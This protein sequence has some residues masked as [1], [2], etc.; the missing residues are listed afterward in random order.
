M[1]GRTIVGIEIVVTVIRLGRAMDNRMV[2]KS[3]LKYHQKAPKKNIKWNSASNKF[4]FKNDFAEIGID[5]PSLVDEKREL[6]IVIKIFHSGVISGPEKSVLLIWIT[7]LNIIV[8]AI[9]WKGIRYKRWVLLQ[10]SD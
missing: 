6:C 10:K 3:L 2:N 5:D 9:F 7:I 8:V 1:C 4:H